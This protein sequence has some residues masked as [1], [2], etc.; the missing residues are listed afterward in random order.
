MNVHP[1]IP[2][3]VAEHVTEA[4]FVHVQLTVHPMF[5]NAGV[6]DSVPSAQKVSVPNVLPVEA[7]DFAAVQ[8]AQAAVGIQ[9]TTTPSMSAQEELVDEGLRISQLTDQDEA[10]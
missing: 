1:G 2:A 8:H 10:G 9:V 7:Y 6:A 4:V 3:R 5:G